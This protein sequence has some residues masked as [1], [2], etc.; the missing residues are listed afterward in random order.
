MD[1]GGL[2]TEEQE[3]LAQ[4]AE[5]TGAT[6]NEET[7][8]QR[9]FTGFSVLMSMDGRV[10]VTGLDS[11]HVELAVKPSN[12]LVFMLASGVAKDFAA[13]DTA[14]ATVAIHMEQAQAMAQQM[15]E[16]QLLQHID[17]PG[18]RRG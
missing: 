15:Q 2:S 8:K 11:P 10:M 4:M 9:F 1:L 17:L 13:L 6:G 16:Q 18:S 3:R 5:E 12:D 7:P 14:Q